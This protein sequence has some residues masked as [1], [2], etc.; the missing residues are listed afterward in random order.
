M[1]KGD[2]VNMNQQKLQKYSEYFIVKTYD[3]DFLQRTSPSTILG[4]MQEVA[5]NHA[6]SLG[7]GYEKSYE[8]NFIWIL[9]S[10]KYEFRSIPRVNDSLEVFTWPV[11][12]SGLKALRR[13]EFRAGGK[14]IG[15]GYHYWIMLDILKNKPV[16]SDYFLDVIKDIPVYDSDIFKLKRITLPKE[17]TSCFNKIVMN[18]DI[19]QNRHVNNVKYGEIIFNA[20]PQQLIETHDI[21]SFQIDYLKESKLKEQLEIST[22]YEQNTLFVLGKIK[23]V[24][25]FQAE[26]I[27]KQ[28]I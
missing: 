3:V 4:Y 6:Y 11:G 18:R 17:M 19:D 9:R 10:A 23:Q 26:L 5:T 8:H 15:S 21:I 2:Y 28:R 22:H 16:I 1:S 24:K 25:V 14:S 7:L 20:I 27:L 12:V 13:F